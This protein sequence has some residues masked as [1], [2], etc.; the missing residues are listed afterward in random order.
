MKAVHR[1]ATG[2]SH[3]HLHEHESEPQRGLPEALP[4]GERLL[5]Q[6]SPDWRSLAV[7]AFHL[8]KLVVYFALLLLLRVAFDLG[9]GK[10]VTSAVAALGG[11]A[12]LAAVALGLVTL[13]AWLS[14]TQAVYTITT[15]RVV[16]R[17]GI[18][19]TVT[20][21]LPYAQIA[22]AAMLRHRAGTGDLPLTLTG[23]QRI[24]Y[25]QLW[26]HARPWQV[27]QTQPMLRCVPQPEQVAALLTQAWREA[28]GLAAAPAAALAAAP[29]S[30]GA[31]TASDN[32]PALHGAIAGGTAD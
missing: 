10:S 9:D 32:H 13:L 17:I 18:V 11:L 6:G 5:W 16:M 12:L 2:H 24:A 25:L 15:K 29:A 23:T 1:P 22:S 31:G 30:Q 19:L 21:N 3:G 28:R 8:R 14:A 20:Y 27:R 26:P 7:H 4:A